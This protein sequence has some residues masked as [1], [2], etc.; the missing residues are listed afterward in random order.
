MGTTTATAYFGLKPSAF[1]SIDG[2]SSVTAY[3]APRFFAGIYSS[4]RVGRFDSRDRKNSLPH[5]SVPIGFVTVNGK[6]L[7]VEID[8]DTWYL[9]ISD[10]INRRLGG[11]NAPTIPDIVNAL[12]AMQGQGSAVAT[13]TA[14]LSQ[15]VMA[16]SAATSA[17]VEVIQSAAIPGSAQIPVVVTSP[18]ELPPPRKTIST[19]T[20]HSE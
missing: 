5:S 12:L 3:F 8:R 1:L 4:Q 15:V 13:Q 11:S 17:A 19:T 18:P 2:V 14:A 16:N 10:L 9:F 6:K 7:P 20:Y